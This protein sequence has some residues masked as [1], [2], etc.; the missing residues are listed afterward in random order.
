MWKKADVILAA[1][2]LAFG[3]L[4]VLLTGGGD[5]QRVVVRQGDKILY[6]GSILED[7]TVEI[8]GVY[9]NTVQIQGGKVFFAA[10]DCPNQD[11]VRMGALGQGGGMLA[12]APNGVIVTIEGGQGEV[13]IIAG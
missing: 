12:C 1:V 2:L 5:S 9:H 3:C 7:K 6:E 10:S 11:C 13:D 4:G 8:G